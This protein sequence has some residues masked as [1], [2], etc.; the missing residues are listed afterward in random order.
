MLVCEIETRT[1]E[2]E[3]GDS[4]CDLT[5]ATIRITAGAEADTTTSV[6]SVVPLAVSR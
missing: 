4:A 3:V 5:A 6:N 2:F 1:W